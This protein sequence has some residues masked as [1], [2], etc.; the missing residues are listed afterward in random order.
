MVDQATVCN[1]GFTTGMNHVPPTARFFF[2][3]ISVNTM[4]PVTG[5]KYV[6]CLIKRLA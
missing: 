4:L 2:I 5:L 6:H 1:L 3:Y